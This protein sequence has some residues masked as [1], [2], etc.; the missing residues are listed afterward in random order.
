MDIPQDH[1]IHTNRLSKRILVW[2]LP[3][4]L[5]HWLLVASVMI[6]FL[7]GN[8][9]GNAMEI[10]EWSGFV[11]L[12]LLLFRLVWGF[13]GGRQSR[14]AAFVRGP[15]AVVRYAAGIVR[16][17]APRCLGHNPLGGWSILAMLATLLIQAL[18]GLF[19]TDDILTQGPLYPSVSEAVSAYLTRIHRLNQNLIIGLIV[20][21]LLA[22]VF[23]LIVKCENL[24]KPMILGIKDW[25][26][27]A[28]PST[29]NHVLAAAIAG[30]AA[31]AVFLVVR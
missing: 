13:V 18:T 16:G 14:F 2:D 4:R 28:Q 3:T 1:A 27:S 15:V 12:S 29:A 10:H 23:Y 11:I 24:I 19:A 20:V 9:G 21:H 30:L 25:H 26:E 5:F 17:D 8:I 31:L 6:S 7:T 22:V